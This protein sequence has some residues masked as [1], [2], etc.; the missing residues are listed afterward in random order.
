MA[1]PFYP[2]EAHLFREIVRA[3]AEELS[4]CTTAELSELVAAG[5]ITRVQ[6]GGLLRDELVGLR[7]LKANGA[8]AQWRADNGL[9]P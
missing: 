6:T 2:A 5:L 9:T 3:E 1:K 4:N 8:Y 7:N